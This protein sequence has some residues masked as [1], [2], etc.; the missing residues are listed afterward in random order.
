MH[1]LDDGRHEKQIGGATS[2]N[3]W[4]RFRWMELADL[5]FEV[6]KTELME[7]EE[8]ATPGKMVYRRRVW[9]RD[10]EAVKDIAIWKMDSM[11]V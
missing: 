8:G 10:A 3:E 6:G 11:D 2:K 1:E 7:D 4:S 9:K 5:V